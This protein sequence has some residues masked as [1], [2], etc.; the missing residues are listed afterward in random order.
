MQA[1]TPQ[2][3][4]DTQ[5]PLTRRRKRGRSRRRRRNAR[6][7]RRQGR[8]WVHAALEVPSRFL[9]DLRLGP[10][11]GKEA[12]ELLA[13]VALADAARR[14]PPSRTTVGC[15]DGPLLLLIDDHLPYPAAILRVFGHLKHRRRRGRRGRRPKPT[16]KPPADL[17]TGVV[18]KRRDERG[19]LLGVSTRALFGRRRDILARIE[20]LGIGC[21]I[22]TAHVERFKGTLRGHQARLTRRTR[23]G[24]RRRRTLRWSLWLYRDL[25]NWTRPHRSLAGRS[26]AQAIGLADGVWTVLEYTRHPVHVS[27][28]QRRHWTDQ[29]NNA[30]ESAVEAY[31]RSKD[32]PTS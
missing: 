10:R 28:A 20:A 17:L 30:M 25:Y 21:K 19:N 31:E 1:Q 4:Q 14:E 2:E 8:N 24:S 27:D 13:S 16:L 26:P 7:H 11:T 5:P 3:P 22:H 32:L 9:I 23:N 29:R 18:R 6:P 15:R 12:A